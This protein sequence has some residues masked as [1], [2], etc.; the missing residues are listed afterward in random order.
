MLGKIAPVPNLL[1]LGRFPKRMHHVSR[2][3][4]AAASC[5]LAATIAGPALAAAPAPQ[6]VRGTIASVGGN[7]LT[8]TTASGPVVVTLT[9]KTSIAGATP[10]TVADIKSGEFL[11]IA[12]VATAGPNR[13]LEVVV[14]ADAM[15][16]AGEGDYPWDSG[17]GSMK[18]STMT[19]GTVATSHSTMTNGTAT[20]MS[21]AGSKTITVTYTGGSRK[22]TIP[23]S[24]PVVHVAPGTKALLVPGAAVF[25]VAT[26]AAHPAALFM[27]AGE[28]GT[29][30]PM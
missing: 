23:N 8:V 9:P 24:A 13:A 4:A 2:L 21:G 14:F 20:A 17:G 3:F 26:K 11:G 18:H 22:L 15:R 25:I 27:V 19:N 10:G 28:N 1:Q 16:G 30:L 6:H 5:A 7:T 12:S 29:K